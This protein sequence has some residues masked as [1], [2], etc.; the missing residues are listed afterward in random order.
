MQYDVKIVARSRNHFCYRKVISITNSERVS[1][2]LVIQHAKRMCHIT[3]S[4][5][6]FLAEPYSVFHI[7]LQPAR[8]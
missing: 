7:I 8:F 6:A 2:A 4:S 1:V 5:V 3:L